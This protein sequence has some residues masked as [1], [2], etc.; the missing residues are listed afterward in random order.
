MK[1]PFILPKN[2]EK[3]HTLANGFVPYQAIKLDGYV[4]TKMIPEDTTMVKV[5][6]ITTDKILG[7]VR[8]I[9]VPRLRT[10]VLSVAGG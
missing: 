5:P 8:I 10:S 1:F 2:L 4:A 3:Q 7:F 6:L 9:R